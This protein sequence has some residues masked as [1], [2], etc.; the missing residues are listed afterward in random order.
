M[1]GFEFH[2]TPRTINKI[3]HFRVQMEAKSSKQYANLQPIATKILTI[4]KGWLTMNPVK[5][6]NDESA[7]AAS[8]P[9]DEHPA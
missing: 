6:R 7:L 3:Q 9:P 4:M 5:R 1:T 8:L 2:P